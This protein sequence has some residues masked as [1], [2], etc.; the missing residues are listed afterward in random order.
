MLPDRRHYFD[1]SHCWHCDGSSCARKRAY[2]M[3]KCVQA[4]HP[5]SFLQPSRAPVIRCF[6]EFPPFRSLA[7]SL[8]TTIFIRIGLP[9]DQIS[10]AEAAAEWCR[11]H[12]ASIPKHVPNPRYALSH[13]LLCVAQL[14]PLPRFASL[15]DLV[16][17]ANVATSSMVRCLL[18]SPP[19]LPRSPS[20]GHAARDGASDET[21]G[22]KAMHATV[23]GGN[24]MRQRQLLHQS[25]RSTML[26]HSR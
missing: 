12:L 1:T 13:L 14:T 16:L 21:R 22:V 10:T 11:S 24:R 4:M 26:R 15:C 19:T 5:A 2:G 3:Y 9:S 23:R 17:R 18:I 20:V 8:S 6:I 7:S 25:E